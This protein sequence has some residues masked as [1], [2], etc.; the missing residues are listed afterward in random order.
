MTN[1]KIVLHFGVYF[2]IFTVLGI[3][4]LAQLLATCSFSV[5]LM[6]GVIWH[7]STLYIPSFYK[8][9]VWIHWKLEW[10]SQG[11]LKLELCLFRLWWKSKFVFFRLMF[12]FWA[13]ILL[14]IMA[15]LTALLFGK[16]TLIKILCLPSWDFSNT[17][18]PAR[19]K[20]AHTVEFFFFCFFRW[21]P[22]STKIKSK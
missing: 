4:F 5:G 19:G 18:Q 11:I 22:F 20:N 2:R 14:S 15:G 1:L 7:L 6:W 16:A 13:K 10:G 21:T 9:A 3:C 17:Y 8:M 12:L